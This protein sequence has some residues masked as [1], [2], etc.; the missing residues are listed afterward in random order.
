ML[1]LCT[2]LDEHAVA[3]E[4]LERKITSRDALKDG[5]AAMALMQLPR[6]PDMPIQILCKV[7]AFLLSS[8]SDTRGKDQLNLRL[9][10]ERLDFQMTAWK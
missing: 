1:R 8:D 7:F 10:C 6:L 2:L 9:T 3:C 5:V 4:F